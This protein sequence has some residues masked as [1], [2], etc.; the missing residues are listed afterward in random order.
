MSTLRTLSVRHPSR[1][2]DH[3][4]LFAHDA[5]RTIYAVLVDVNNSHASLTQ[6]DR[7]R[8]SF[9]YLIPMSTLLT[10]AQSAARDVK[11]RDVP[12][13]N[14]GPRG[15]QAIR[16][17]KPCHSISAFGSKCAMVFPRKP[18]E[19]ASEV[20]VVQMLPCANTRQDPEDP[21][22][23]AAR[24]FFRFVHPAEGIT[25]YRP[26]SFVAPCSILRK[27]VVHDSAFVGPSRTV[28]ILTDDGLV[29]IVRPSY[30]AIGR[31]PNT[32]H[33]R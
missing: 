5:S 33:M 24:K 16:L 3:Q 20:F 6:L 14:W 13:E 18:G 12:W 4:A 11:E 26:S 32:N 1:N 15:T 25:S 22:V 19:S 7:D 27:V 31:L 2:L 29:L 8:V 28:V 10:R 23:A 9:L 30:C 21:D 17:R